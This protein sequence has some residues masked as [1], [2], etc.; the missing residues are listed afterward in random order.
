[1]F[2]Y[3]CVYNNII[4]LYYISFYLLIPFVTLRKEGRK[5]GRKEI[6]FLPHPT[7]G[8][9]TNYTENRSGNGKETEQQ[10]AP[11]RRH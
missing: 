4:A 9:F 7:T 10:R 2:Y 3:Y 6:S 11:Y 1:M 8:D 5:E